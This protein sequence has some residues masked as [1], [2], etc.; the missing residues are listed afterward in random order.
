MAEDDNSFVGA[1]RQLLLR[2]RNGALEG[3]KTRCSAK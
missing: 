3:R 1:V 2:Q